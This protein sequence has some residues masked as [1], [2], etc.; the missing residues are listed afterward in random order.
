M[1][2]LLAREPQDESSVYKL[3]GM[4]YSR[5]DLCQGRTAVAL[6]EK[7]NIVGMEM[8]NMEPAP[9]TSE[10]KETWFL[11]SPNLRNRHLSSLML[12]IMKTI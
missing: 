8:E 4:D 2:S 6:S 11:S 7:I 1:F 5:E 3:I 10:V 9:E 12:G